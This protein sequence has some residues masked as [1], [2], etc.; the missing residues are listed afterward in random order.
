MYFKY[1]QAFLVLNRKPQ[2]IVRWKKGR[3]ANGN[4]DDILTLLIATVLLQTSTPAENSADMPSL[5]RTCLKSDSLGSF[6]NTAL[7]PGT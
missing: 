2:Q 7:C 6:M 4:N 3:S 5:I 1:E